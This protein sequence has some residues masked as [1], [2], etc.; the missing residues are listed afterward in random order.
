M[1]LYS[2][3]VS[4][5]SSGRDAL[6]QHQRTLCRQNKRVFLVENLVHG[7]AAVHV[8]CSLVEVFHAVKMLAATHG[9]H[10]QTK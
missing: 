3:N 1:S 2:S 6:S 8:W 5:L 4:V 9:F 7:N 10:V